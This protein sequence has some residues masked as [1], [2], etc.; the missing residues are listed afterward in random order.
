M[1]TPVRCY[2]RVS[3][4][5]QAQTGFSL[6]FQDEKLRNY[7]QSQVDWVIAST[8]T[9]DG[10]SAKNTN[11]PDLQRLLAECQPGDVVLVYRLDRLTRSVRD[12]DML[13]Q[14]FEK[15][16]IYLRSV[17][18]SIDTTTAN[19]RLFLRMVIEIA[20]WERETI[21]ERVVDG[22]QRKIREGGW[23]GGR[24]P[25]GYEAIPSGVVKGRKELKKLVPDPNTAHLVPS[26][27]QRYL[28]G[29]GIRALAVWLNDD[30]AVK[31]SRGVKFRA[32]GISR[33]LQN[34]FYCGLVKIV[35][36]RTGDVSYV[37]GEHPALIS[38][39]LFEAVSSMFESRKMTAPRHATGRYPL[40]GISRCGICLG[41]IDVVAH[42][43]KTA[44]N[45]YTYR[46][47]RYGSGQGCTFTS[48]AG[49]LAEKA[50]IDKIVS[51]AL[52]PKHIDELIDEFH[53]TQENRSGLDAAEVARLRTDLITAKTAI[54]RWDQ[55]YETG[56]LEWEAYRQRVAPHQDRIKT[57]EERL[58]EYEME[59]TPLPDIDSIRVHADSIAR[60][61]DDLTPPERKSLLMQFCQAF[62]VVI[63]LNSGQQVRI[64]PIA[65]VPD[66]A[67]RLLG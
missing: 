58:A 24:P 29:Y 23:T 4:D 46:C 27:F 65:S 66:G 31:T 10:Y 37:E 63:L 14:T 7:I 21:S 28:D 18:E 41:A 49:P 22:M 25:F 64:V 5:E 8:Y 3:T 50:V 36:K 52:V 2:R 34:E 56:D 67:F 42:K 44:P 1:S 16:S 30:V 55:A 57:I 39:D 45:Y 15:R 40:T 60:V 35:D 38:R 32:S 13:L 19:G 26:I 43:R 53:K 6:A 9:D 12:L 62:R 20:Q 54:Q 48:F 61:W 17:T 47:R 33:I 59:S 11:R 51:Y